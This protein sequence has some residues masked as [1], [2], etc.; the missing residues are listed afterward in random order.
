MKRVVRLVALALVLSASTAFAQAPAP[1]K[2]LTIEQFVSYAFPYELVSAKKADRIAWI[3]NQEGKRN[4]YTAA[5][6]SFTP[7]R[8][9]SFMND[10]GNDLTGLAISADGSVV[11][12]VRGHTPNREGWIAN[13]SHLPD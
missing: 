6:P 7:V 1:T 10:D 11:V 5:A 8:L 4:V 13:P 2:G 9:T 12:F 3:E